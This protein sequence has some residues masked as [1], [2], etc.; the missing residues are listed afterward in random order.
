VPETAELRPATER[1]LA[2]LPGSR[3]VWIAVWALVPWVNAG[4]NLLL[5][6][7]GAVWE[8]S[9][10]LVILNY[11]ALSFAVVITVWG[12]ARIARRLQALRATSS[13][14]VEGDSSERFRGVNNVTGPLVA[15]AA[16]SVALAAGT[17]ASDGL[18]PALLRGATWLVLGVPLWT[19]LW[20][21]VTLQ[22]GL[23]RLGRER[24]LPEVARGD[25]S[26]GLRPFGGVA[27]SGLWI[28]LAW[29]VP[30]L[31]TGLPDVV[32]VALGAFVLLGGLATF[33]LS[34]FRL[35]RQ[36]VELKANELAIARELY[37]RAYEPVRTSRSLETLEQQHS[38]L[39]AADGLEK[40]GHA[41]HEWPIDEG[42]FA[43]VVTI[44]TSVVAI[45]VARLILDPLGL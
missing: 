6:T 43:R 17:L 5:G 40:R 18:T 44:A 32:G 33:F 12:T 28:L 41:I 36:M 25:P 9:D 35:H 10:A 23:D 11:A 16:T 20:T 45:T 2:Q 42:I 26:L 8:Q 4:A 27:F 7:E 30:V 34:M 19:F 37:A 15:T 21:Y 24:L 39:S 3:L 22:L 13:A 14:L 1:I 31:L 29:L 38:L